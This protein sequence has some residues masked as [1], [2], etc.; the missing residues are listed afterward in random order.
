MKKLLLPIIL[1]MVS[2]NVMALQVD[3]SG[4]SDEQ[5]AQLALTAAQMKT[6]TDVT[7]QVAKE[8]AEVGQ[9]IGIGLVA[10]ASELGMSVDKLMTTTTGKLAVGV[11]IY[12]V[13]GKD[14]IGILFGLVWLCI[15]IPIWIFFWAT[16][17]SRK[18]EDVVTFE[19][20]KREDGKTK[21]KNYGE[22]ST[23]LQ[24]MYLGVLVGI[25]VTGL[26]SIFG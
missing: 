3:T 4:L 13:A 1:L 21:I 6:A 8:W 23:E 19:K 22:T 2:F 26:I 7:P 15:A 17:G 20:G 9:A 24:F 14:I 16:R 11:I 10:T 12:K 5:H 25:T 18:L